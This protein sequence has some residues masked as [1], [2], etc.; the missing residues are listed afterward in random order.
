[1][2]SKQFFIFVFIFF[3]RFLIAI[4]FLTKFWATQIA[5]VPQTPE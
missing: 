5:W 3:K 1:M 4:W 2:S